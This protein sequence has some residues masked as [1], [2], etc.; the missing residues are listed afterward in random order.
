MI[1][2]YVLKLIFIFLIIFYSHPLC[3]Q[4][5]DVL[6][7]KPC[8]YKLY[9]KTKFF[10]DYPYSNYKEFILKYVSNNFPDCL[11][12]IEYNNNKLEKFKTDYCI[13]DQLL[14][15]RS[16]KKTILVDVK[17]KQLSLFNSLNTSDSLNNLFLDSVYSGSH[18]G[19][20]DIKNNGTVNKISSIDLFINNRCIKI[21]Q[22]NFRDLYNPSFCYNYS[23]IKQIEAYYKKKIDVVYIYITGSLSKDKINNDQNIC[24]LFVSKIIVN[25]S[26]GKVDRITIPA[27]YLL[28][29]GWMAC[30]EFWPF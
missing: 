23:S 8:S 14:L 30:P 16:G 20:I 10:R 27:C 24:D 11:E 12:Y 6:H 21:D 19:F 3:C 5:V 7:N 22:A 4:E 18:Y 2:K 26:S 15:K 17:I 25:I 9:L 13:E 1:E 28:Q 29:Y